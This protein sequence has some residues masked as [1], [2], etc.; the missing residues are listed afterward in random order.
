MEPKSFNRC[1]I[2]W[3]QS[4]LPA[5]KGK[6]TLSMDGKAIRSTG[7]M[8][9]QEHPLQNLSAHIAELGMTFAQQAVEERSNGSPA[10]R[11]LP[12]LLE[13]EGCLVAADALHCQ[14]ETAQA[15]VAR[16]ADYL[17]CA[18]ENQ[19]TLKEENA[20]YVQD[21]A[22]RTSMDFHQTHDKNSG[23]LEHRRAYATLEVAWLSEC[24]SWPQLACIGAVHSRVT[25][26]K[27]TTK[28]GTTDQWRY[29]LSSRKLGAKDLLHH[30][31]SEWSVESLHWL[32]D[33]HF[34]EDF[35]AA[36][37]TATSS[38]TST[39]SARSPSTASGATRKRQTQNS[40]SPKSCS[41]ACSNLT[42]SCKSSQ[43]TSPSLENMKVDSRG[44]DSADTR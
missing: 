23:R 44:L 21:G 12:E 28:K 16:K 10:L 20:D 19:A 8:G 1:F 37:R 2:G 27:G 26:K 6:L 38:R 42:I 30:A 43:I 35:S 18:K 34:G 15:I 33:V 32:L 11:E 14:K 17:L 36:W 39:S 22:L 25:T 5:D 29:Y 13:I 9:G 24:K 4:L 40:P 3:V 7:R 41:T 31:R